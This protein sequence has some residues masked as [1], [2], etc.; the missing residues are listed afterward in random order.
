MGAGRWVFLGE[1]LCWTAAATVGVPLKQ[2][3]T[4]LEKC[5][6]AVAKSPSDLC[7]HWFKYRN[8]VC[9]SRNLN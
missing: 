5:E 1:V 6:A 3:A 2:I 8:I 7:I 9:W 4:R